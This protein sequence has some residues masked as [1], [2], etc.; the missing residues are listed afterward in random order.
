MEETVTSRWAPS[1]MR[2]VIGVLVLAVLFAAVMLARAIFFG[3]SDT[4]RTALER[5]YLDAQATVQRNPN[6]VKARINLA[7]AL[8]AMGRYNNALGQTKE[9]IK[10]DPGQPKLYYIAGVANRYK[11]NLKEALRYFDQAA[12]LE[13]EVSDFYADVYYEMG[14][15][16]AQ[17]KDYK[18]ALDAYTKSY[19]SSTVDP[20]DT[21]YKKALMEEKLKM[22]QDAIASYQEI[23]A[24]DPG[25]SQA[26]GALKRLGVSPQPSQP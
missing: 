21:M 26:L 15:V 22:K 8:V 1:V 23:L 10:I 18:K 9:A 16:Y 13:G 11:N 24:F 19:E 3:A 25:N 17:Q 20:I 4:P 6:D 7:A 5:A 2:L 12:K 14:E